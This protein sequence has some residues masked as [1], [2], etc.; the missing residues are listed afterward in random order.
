M[1]ETG[2]RGLDAREHRRT[3]RLIRFAGTIV[4]FKF[5]SVEMVSV[6]FASKP[7][8][9]TYA[10]ELRKPTHQ[11]VWFADLRIRV[12]NFRN[13]YANEADH[14]TKSDLKSKTK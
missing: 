7:H 11:S 10:D 3:Q 5:C 9:E 1:S 8:R 14:I 2:N 6:K 4:F 13:C 12:S